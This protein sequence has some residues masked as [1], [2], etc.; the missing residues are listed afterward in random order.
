MVRTENELLKSLFKVINGGAEPKP[1]AQNDNDIEKYRDADGYIN[2]KNV[3][4]INE[5]KKVFDIVDKKNYLEYL[6]KKDNNA[7]DLAD[8]LA[9]ELFPFVGDGALNIKIETPNGTGCAKI[10]KIDSNMNVSTDITKY[11][12]VI[13]STSQNDAKDTTM[14]DIVKDND[15]NPTTID[16]ET[17]DANDKKE[18]L[19]AIMLCDVGGMYNPD[20]YNA[21][22]HIC[23]VIHFPGEMVLRDDNTDVNTTNI[24]SYILLPNIWG[25]IF[26]EAAKEFSGLIEDGHK[27]FIIDPETFELMQITNPDDLWNYT[28]TRVQ[29]EML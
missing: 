17:E 7:Q 12:Q 3:N 6:S 5:I 19:N 26:I 21:V 13:P 27:V 16:A 14:G 24:T 2:L 10:N 9:T 25:K 28:M 23:R 4:D 29:E 18:S 20:F 22:L 15:M 8:M 11:A 1:S